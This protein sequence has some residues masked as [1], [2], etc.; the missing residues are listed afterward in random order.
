MHNWLIFQ[1]CRARARSKIDNMGAAFGRSHRVGG[2]E[3]EGDA[4]G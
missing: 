3:L 1:Y 2:G 4:E